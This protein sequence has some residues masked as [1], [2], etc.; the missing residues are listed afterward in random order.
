MSYTT[1]INDNIVSWKLPRIEVKPVIG[2]LD[3]VTIHNFLLEDSISVSQPVTP[4]WVVE[5]GERV[6]ETGSQSTQT[7]ISKSSIVL[8]IDDVLDAET[9]LGKTL[10]AMCE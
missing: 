5:G 9:K 6:Q 7:T 1:Y 8:L 10:Y 2:H 4:S 3:L